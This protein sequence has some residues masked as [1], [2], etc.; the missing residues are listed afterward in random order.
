MKSYEC[1]RSQ[2]LLERQKETYIR[3]IALVPA[4][5]LGSVDVLK[6]RTRTSRKWCNDGSI[7]VTG[8]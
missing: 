8:F 1:I 6:R 7:P 5:L 3:N 4:D 2:K